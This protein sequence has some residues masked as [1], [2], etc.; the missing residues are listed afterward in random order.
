MTNPWPFTV[1]NLYI[2]DNCE[3]QQMELLSKARLVHGEV[4]V[5][6]Q[7]PY[8]FITPHQHPNIRIKSLNRPPKHK[9]QAIPQQYK[10]PC[11]LSKDLANHE[12]LLIHSGKGQLYWRC[13]SEDYIQFC[14][15]YGGSWQET[16]DLRAANQ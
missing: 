16:C 12:Y 4:F 5:G 7:S 8:L 11:I 1:H 3:A 14:I 10:M 9:W 15:D 2:P 13:K 6:D